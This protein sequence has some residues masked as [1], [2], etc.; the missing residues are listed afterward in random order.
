MLSA[1]FVPSPCTIFWQR[2]TMCRSH[3]Y[4]SCLHCLG[5]THSFMPAS[6]GEVL[7]YTQ[8]HS[9]AASTCNTEWRLYF[10]RHLF[11]D[12]YW[13]VSICVL[14]TFCVPLTLCM[15]L[16]LVKHIDPS[17]VRNC[18]AY[19]FVVVV[20]SEILTSWSQMPQSLLPPSWRGSRTC[21]ANAM[22]SWCLSMLTRCERVT[23]C[24][25]VFH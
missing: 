10:F 8:Q 15:S 7:L 19:F 24:T 23:V 25:L 5:W 2:M 3:C 13:T 22:P 14:S 11:V 9:M 20:I 12:V 17:V 1:W 21:P 4:V 16:T 18:T 6:D